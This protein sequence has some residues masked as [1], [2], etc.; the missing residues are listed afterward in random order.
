MDGRNE[1][2]AND[3]TQRQE[4]RIYRPKFALCKPNAT[5]NGCSME[6][7][8]HPAHD[9]VDGS[10]WAR[11][12]NQSSVGDFH[13]PVPT[14]PRFDWKNALTVKLDFTDLSKMLQV[15]R[16]ECESLEEGRGLL[17]RSPVGLTNIKL[18]HLIDPKPGYIFEVFRMPAP[19]KQGI[20]AHIHISPFEATGLTAAIEN[21]LGVIC[22]GIPMVIP[23][24]TTAY[25]Q[26]VREMRHAQAS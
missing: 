13:G 14:Y 24:D 21:S 23:H 7:E 20:R 9:Q 3:R 15:F 4:V 19:G 26:A 10:I 8:L 2:T 12:A 11:L 5:G 22:F 16:G 25:R 1:V 6:L 18:E 17:H